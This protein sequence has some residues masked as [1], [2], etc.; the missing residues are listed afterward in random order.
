MGCEMMQKVKEPIGFF[1]FK[2]KSP[3]RIN[4]AFCLTEVEVR[5]CYIAHKKYNTARVVPVKV[6]N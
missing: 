6:K 1:L 3:N 4:I 5:S 2:M